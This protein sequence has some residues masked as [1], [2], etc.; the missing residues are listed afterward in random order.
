MEPHWCYIACIANLFLSIKSVTP[1]EIN[2][3]MFF[4]YKC[5]AGTKRAISFIRKAFMHVDQHYDQNISIYVYI[6]Y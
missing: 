1:V 4:F 5:K 3:S 2:V 6:L